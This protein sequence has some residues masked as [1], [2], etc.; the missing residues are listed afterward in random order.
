MDK[1]LTRNPQPENSCYIAFIYP[2]LLSANIELNKSNLQHAMVKRQRYAGTNFKHTG[3]FSG[4]AQP[5]T[6]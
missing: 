3:D 5:Q 1:T 6:D 2:K 4:P